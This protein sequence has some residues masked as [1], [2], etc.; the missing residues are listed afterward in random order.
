MT[1]GGTKAV[2]IDKLPEPYVSLAEPYVDE[3]GIIQPLVD[4]GIGTLQ[5]ITSQKDTVRANHYHKNDSHYMY[6]VHGRMRYYFRPAGSSDEPQHVDV[7]SGQMVFTPS[8]EEHAVHFLEDCIFLNI[9]TGKR[10]Q[11]TYENDIVRVNLFTLD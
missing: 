10:D 2:T 6:V 7:G 3:R 1:N 5:I 9:T 8:M 4:H 11:S